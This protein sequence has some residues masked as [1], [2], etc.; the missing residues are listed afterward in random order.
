MPTSSPGSPDAYQQIGAQYVAS[1]RDDLLAKV[2]EQARFGSLDPEWRSS[3]VL[4]NSD[5]TRTWS[6]T[7][8]GQ[9]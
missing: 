6:Q 1:M 3:V 4:P 8:T 2:L 7:M 9:W 5:C